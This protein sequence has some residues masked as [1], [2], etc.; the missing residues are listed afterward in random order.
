M[1]HG[2]I[3]AKGHDLYCLLQDIGKKHGLDNFEKIKEEGVL[4]QVCSCSPDLVQMPEQF[5]IGCLCD[6]EMQL[7]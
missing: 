6:H 2:W 4:E 7:Q 3:C 1:Q 5:V